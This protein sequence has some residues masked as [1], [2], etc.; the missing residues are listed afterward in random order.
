MKPKQRKH[1]H[2][3]K[4]TLGV[5]ENLI[6]KI[7]QITL[8]VGKRNASWLSELLKNRYIFFFNFGLAEEKG[9]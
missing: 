4:K 9:N 5:P 3:E 2:I 1:I 6:I 7:F 8:Q